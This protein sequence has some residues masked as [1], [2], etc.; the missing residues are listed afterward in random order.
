MTTILRPEGSAQH[1]PRPV[2]CP[3]CGL[4]ADNAV[5]TRT[6]L[7]ASATYICTEAHLFALVW[8]EVA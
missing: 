4:T 8:V 2:P 7:T 5:V 3:V 1:E 6:E